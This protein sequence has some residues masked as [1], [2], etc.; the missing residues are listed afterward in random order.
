[1]EFVSRANFLF[2]FFFF[3]VATLVFYHIKK[4]DLSFSGF[5]ELGLY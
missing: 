4:R 2:L 5:L 3:L 1:V